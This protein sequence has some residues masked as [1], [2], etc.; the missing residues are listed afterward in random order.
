MKTVLIGLSP[1]R[2][3]GEVNQTIHTLG[4]GYRIL[5]TDRMEEIEPWIDDIEIAAGHFPIDF[6]RRATNLRWYQQWG[7]GTD[8]LM[9]HPDLIEKDFML[10]NASGVH[11]IPISEHILALMLAFARKLPDAVR[12]Q[13]KG[14]W[15]EV[16]GLGELAGK[17]MLLIGVGAIGKYTAHIA[18]ALGMR[19][20]GLRRNPGKQIPGIDRMVGK[21]QLYQVLPEADFVVLTIPLTHETRHMIDEKAFK[22]MKQSA[23]IVNIG[24]GATIDEAALILALQNGQIAGAGLDVFEK[25]PLSEDSPLWKMENVIITA[26]YSGNTPHYDQRAFEIFIDNLKRYT[27]GVPMRNLV[28]KKRGY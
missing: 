2:L 25:E 21:E 24:R 14:M 23:F 6:L 22:A 5:I 11:S 15:V 1:E 26:H 27:T 10:T 17:T 8:W 3:S 9:K 18:A 16:D 28:D 4:Q 19:V 13:A 20:V 12:A 7:A